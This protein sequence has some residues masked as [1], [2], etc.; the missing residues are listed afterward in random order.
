MSEK[1]TGMDNEETLDT[2]VGTVTLAGAP[3]SGKSTLLNK[4]IGQRLSIATHKPQTTRNRILAVHN[5]GNC[6]MIFLDTPG[7]HGERGLI[8]RRMLAAA[9]SS[10]DEADVLCWLIAADRGLRKT[11]KRE[12]SALSEHPRVIVLLNKM[13]LV[14]RQDL[15]PYMKQVGEL[16]PNAE[17]LPLSARKGE[18]VETLLELLAARLPPGPWLYG[19]DV[20]TDMSERFFVAELVREQLFRQLEQELPYRVA[21]SV[22]SWERHGRTL[23]ISV[24]IFTDSKSTRPM[25]IGHGGERLKSIGSAAREK[26]ERLVESRVHLEIFVKVRAN[27]PSDPHFLAEQGL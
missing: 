3:N 24:C 10:M 20:L 26:I 17:V 2:R 14:R 25:I 13:D 27:W 21:V 1:K 7:I 11:D 19:K 5:Q 23:H 8:H 18:N 6:Q 4:I 15:L 16:A 22:E 12:L 9:R